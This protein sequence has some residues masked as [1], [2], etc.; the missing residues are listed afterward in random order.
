MPAD[1]KEIPAAAPKQGQPVTHTL[2]VLFNDQP[3]VTRTLTAADGTSILHA[4]LENGIHLQ[5]NCGGVCA[6]S[7]CHVIIKAGMENLPDMSEAEEDQLDEAIGLTL[8]SRLGCQ[9]K[10]RGD[11][12]V[13]IPQQTIFGGK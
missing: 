6:C 12:T 11:V 7:T 3:G 1:T 2:T 13:L 4:L 5:H 8:T 10:L 9:S